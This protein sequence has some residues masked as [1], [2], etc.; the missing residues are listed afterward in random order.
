MSILG[1]VVELS[2][3]LRKIT[4]AACREELPDVTGEVDGHQVVCKVFYQDW[5]GKEIRREVFVDGYKFACE[6]E[7][8]SFNIL[9]GGI[10]VCY[11]V[12]L[13]LTRDRAERVIAEAGL[14][15]DA[16]ME[17]FYPPENQ[18]MRYNAAVKTLEEVIALWKAWAPKY[19]P[20]SDSFD[21]QEQINQE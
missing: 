19:R 16:I 8:F 3:Q 6:L 11:W 1:Q 15:A 5:Q 20:D 21:C 10:S 2:H 12:W 13:D 4:Q 9:K 7:R 14:P 18:P 17:D